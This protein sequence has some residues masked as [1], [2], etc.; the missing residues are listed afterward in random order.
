M[1]HVESGDRAYVT[2]D[3]SYGMVTR[4]SFLGLKDASPIVELDDGTL[5]GFCGKNATEKVVNKTTGKNAKGVSIEMPTDVRE[6]GPVLLGSIG[7]DQNDQII[8]FEKFMSLPKTVRRAKIEEWNTS[9]DDVDLRESF[10]TTI[11]EELADDELYVRAQSHLILN[12]IVQ[13]T[14]EEMIVKFMAETTHEQRQGMI[15][16][17][18]S[19]KTSKK[20][21]KQFLQV[22]YDLTLTE[23]QYLDI[24]YRLAMSE[25]RVAESLHDD[26]MTQF[27][28]NSSSSTLNKH[29]SSLRKNYSSK[30]F[31]RS[32]ARWLTRVYGSTINRTIL[33]RSREI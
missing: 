25:N 3:D 26:I 18:K 15:V 7:V 9:K 19:L 33:T 13:D 20:G 29:Y 27:F 31:R 30:S 4:T 6:I 22:V 11:V 2:D 23:N 24:E 1:S 5:S 21:R 16:Q 14:R 28:N 12:H 17:W 8:L 10:L 32:R